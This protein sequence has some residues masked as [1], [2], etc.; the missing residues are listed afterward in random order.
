MWELDAFGSSPVGRFLQVEHLVG[1]TV[2]RLYVLAVGIAHLPWLAAESFSVC[3][4]EVDFGYACKVA[5][6]AFGGLD[7]HTLTEFE[8]LPRMESSVP[9]AVGKFRIYVKETDFKY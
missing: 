8:Y 3:V 2:A 7:A 4:L 5:G 1:R 6:F 9:G